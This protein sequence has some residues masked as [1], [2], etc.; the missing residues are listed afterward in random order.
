[1]VHGRALRSPRSGLRCRR[2]G[3]GG[4]V[5]CQRSGPDGS[6]ANGCVARSRARGRLVCCDRGVPSGAAARTS[7]KNA[8]RFSFGSFDVKEKETCH[9]GRAQE[10][11]EMR[12]LMMIRGDENFTKS[13]PPP[14]ELMDAIGEL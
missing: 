5:R 4:H 9:N 10:T 8:C 14:K 1:M 11:R 3:N 7:R 6:L 13:G 2:M 12:Y